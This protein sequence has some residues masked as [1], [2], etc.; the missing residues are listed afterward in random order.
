MCWEGKM[1]KWEPLLKPLSREKWWKTLEEQVEEAYERG[2][3]EVYPPRDDLFTALRLTPPERVKCVILGQDPYHEP[4]QA[5]G[6]AF[7][8]RPGQKIPPSLRNI[9]QELNR[10]LG[11]PIPSHGCLTQWGKQ[12]VLLLNNVLTVYQGAA[13]S[14]KKWGWQ[15]FTTALLREVNR[16]PQPVAYLLWGKDAQSKVKTAALESAEGPRLILTSSHPSPLSAYRGFLGSRPF[17]QVNRFLTEQGCM[18]IDWAVLAR[19]PDTMRERTPY[20]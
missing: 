8:V 6:L 15:H 19:E 18:P 13:N 12:G 20:G 7:S 3:P 9:Y 14:H 1:G 17:S 2:E 16:L 5:H 4:G 11:S 10:D